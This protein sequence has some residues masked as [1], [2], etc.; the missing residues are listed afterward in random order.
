MEQSLQD[1]GR[2]D[3][4]CFGCGPANEHGLH[5]KSYPDADGL[6]IV[7]TITPDERYC[8]WPGV[9]YGGYLAML[10]DCHSNWTAIAAHYKAEGRAPGTSPRIDCATGQL[11]ITY[12]QPTPMGV[13]LNLRATVEGPVG[14]ATRVLCEIHAGGQLTV[15]ANSVFVRIDPKSLSEKARVK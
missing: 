12:R 7:A 8:G 10:V 2:P 14:R 13:P 15:S 3:G 9:V 11:H 1:A 6:H 4:V 5:L